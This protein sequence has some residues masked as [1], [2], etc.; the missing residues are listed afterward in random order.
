MKVSQKLSDM[1]AGS[2]CHRSKTW[3]SPSPTNIKKKKSTGGMS[4]TE[5]LLSAGRRP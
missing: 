3:C 1:G 2:R 5:H 4:H